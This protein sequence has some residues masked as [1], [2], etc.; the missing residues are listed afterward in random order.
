[1][2]FGNFYSF[3]E[4]QKH[5]FPEGIW[6]MH[7]S[8]L[9]PP[10]TRLIH[11]QVLIPV[12]KVSILPVYWFSYSFPTINPPLSANELASYFTK[13]SKANKGENLTLESVTNSGALLTLSPTH[14]LPSNFTGRTT[15]PPAWD[16]TLRLFFI[17][18]H[19]LFSDTAFTSA[20]LSISPS[21]LTCRLQI[22]LV[23][24]LVLNLSSF[25]LLSLSPSQ[26]EM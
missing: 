22:S 10:I 5:V 17:Q 3:S 25:F 11:G 2:Y 14:S 24:A 16:Q 8:P 1:M 9:N 4:S 26:S 20:V 12:P 19:L 6:E 23:F 21:S 13:E 18:F 7:G 15:C